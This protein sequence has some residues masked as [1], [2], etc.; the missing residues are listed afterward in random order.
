M[1]PSTGGPLPDRGRSRNAVNLLLCITAVGGVVFGGWALHDA[2]ET[3][4]NRRASRALIAEECGGLVDA[5]TVMGLD[6]GTDRVVLGDD[7]PGTIDAGAV[8]VP[9]SCVLSRLEEYKGRDQQVSHFRLTVQ[10]LPLQPDL[11]LIDDGDDHPFRLL[12]SPKEEGDVTAR[13]AFPNRNPLGDGRL[14]D[15]GVD[16]VAVVARCEQPLASG[17]TSLVVTAASPSTSDQAGDRAPLARLAR[18]A[19]ERAAEKLGCR[20]ALPELPDTLPA[21]AVDLGPA[22]DRKDSCGWYS[23]HLRAV[24]DHGRL[25]DRAA[26][27]PLTNTGRE[28]GCLLAVGPEET[29][30][31]FPQLTKDERGYTDMDDVLRMTPWWIRTRTYLGDDAASVV[32][33]GRRFPDRVPTGSAGR[34]GEVHYASATCQGRPATLTMSVPGNYERVLGPRLD[35]LFTTYATE[36]ATRR[37]CTGLVL[38]GPE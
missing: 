17:V 33:K 32:V 6:G 7:H 38:P 21:P 30:R 11:H 34:L 31:A 14:G 23:A 27:A 22:A 5:E 13:T 10:G 1:R 16:D 12:S 29:E 36:A 37:G 2:Y 19:A 25:P 18:R 9:D 15:Y 3:H 26:G 4:E 8:S 24:A 20:T 35:E 28:E